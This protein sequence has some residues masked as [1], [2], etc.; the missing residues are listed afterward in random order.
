LVSKI[1]GCRIAAVWEMPC[2]EFLNYLNYI[3]EKDEHMKDINKR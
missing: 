2:T 1:E 3:R